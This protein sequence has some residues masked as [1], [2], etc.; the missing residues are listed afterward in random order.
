M[1]RST[2]SSSV[3]FSIRFTSNQQSSLGVCEKFQE[4]LFVVW[5]LL[6]GWGLVTSVQLGPVWTRLGYS[7]LLQKGHTKLRL[8]S[9]CSLPILNL[10]LN[11][12][13]PYW[14][15]SCSCHFRIYPQ[16]YIR[17]PQSSAGLHE[18][19]CSPRHYEWRV[20]GCSWAQLTHRWP[21]VEGW[22]FAFPFRGM[23]SNLCL[24]G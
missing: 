23:Y 7:E 2:T 22:R 13:W 19:A 20:A 18:E 5:P 24:R 1:Y 15:S 3:K 10:D 9:A 12:L 11:S 4:D 8:T 17:P 6:A 14:N 21:S 16:Q